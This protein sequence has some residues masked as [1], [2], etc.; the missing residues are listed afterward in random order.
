MCEAVGCLREEDTTW[1]S[2]GDWAGPRCW[3]H[4]PMRDNSLAVAYDAMLH[5]GR[6][7]KI[8]EEIATNKKRKK[9]KS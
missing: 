5:M 8:V 2:Q 3:Q 1:W 4:R 6:P 7:R 9:V